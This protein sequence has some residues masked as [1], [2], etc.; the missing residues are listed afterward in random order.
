MSDLVVKLIHLHTLPLKPVWTRLGY[1]ENT[2]VPKV[3]LERIQSLLEKHV[4]ETKVRIFYREKKYSAQNDMNDIEGYRF[5][6]SLVAKHFAPARNV[7]VLGASADLEDYQR[8]QVLQ[9]EDIQ[10][11]VV[12]D[13]VLSEKADYALDFIEKEV[14]VEL[15]RR[16]QHSGRR[17]SCGY[18]DFSLENQR[19]FYDTL[20]FNHYG[21]EINERHILY[22]EKTVTAL[23]PI[24]HAGEG[25]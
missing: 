22:P 12:L 10:Q 20:D 2:E 17:L 13:A 11:A 16:G 5:A 4:Y 6:S 1:R 8:L 14:Q 9:I 7:L 25:T 23:L 24:Y 19:F 21:I 18:G 15:R 3:F